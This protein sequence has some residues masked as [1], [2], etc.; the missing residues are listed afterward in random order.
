VGTSGGK[1]RRTLEGSLGIG[2]GKDIQ[3]PTLHW[4]TFTKVVTRFFYLGF[5]AVLSPPAALQ[6]SSKNV[7]YPTSGTAP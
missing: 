2:I 3:K 7:A 1:F 6:G 5:H 4:Q